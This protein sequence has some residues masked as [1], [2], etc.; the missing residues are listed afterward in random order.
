MDRI[1]F[2]SGHRLQPC[3]F[4]VHIARRAHGAQLPR[5]VRLF[6]SSVVPARGLIVRRVLPKLLHSASEDDDLVAE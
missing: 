1:G 3:R 4:A 5:R 2:V 6:G